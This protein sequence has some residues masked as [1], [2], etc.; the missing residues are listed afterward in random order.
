MLNIALEE[1]AAKR[2]RDSHSVVVEVVVM[3]QLKRA[4]DM[5]ATE[6]T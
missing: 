1:A 2:N 4:V 5:R 3:A 6:M